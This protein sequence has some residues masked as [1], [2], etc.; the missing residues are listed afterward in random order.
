MGEKDHSDKALAGDGALTF[1]P[2]A[3]IDEVRAA[4]TD[5]IARAAL[6]ADICRLNTLYMIMQ[7]G[8]GHIGSSFSSTDLITWL[9]TEELVAANSGA[10]NADTYFSSKGH[11]A[12][13]LYSLLIALGKLDFDLLH[14]LRRLGGLPGH[15][16]V[17]TTPFVATNTGSLGM[18]IAKAYGMARARRFTGR[19]GRIVLMTGDGE[20][21]EGQVWESLQP[22][23]NERLS[24]IVA[25][26][27][28][29]KLQSDSAVS[30]VSDL[31]PLED[32]FR[33]F[34]WEVRRIDGHDFAAMRGAFAHFATVHDRPKV[35]IADT[36]KGKGVS[37]MEG[38]ACGD[39]T[40]HFHAGAPSLKDYLAA[41]AELTARLNDRLARIGWPPLAVAYAP[42]PARVAPAKPE[43]LVLAY[44]DE[45]LQMARART[46]IVVLDAD[47]L[48]DC[49]IEAFK[50]ELPDRFI[51]CG[52]AEQHMV[53]AAGGMALNGI[54][55]VVHSFACFLST[56]ANEQIYNNATERTKI[57]YTATLAGVVPGGP[58]HSHQSV[59][60]IS[61]VGSVPGLTAIEPCTEREARLAIRWAVEQNDASTYLRF[62]NVP[63]D[64]PYSLP[65][66]YAL[67]PG[68]GVTLRDGRDIALVG[69]GPLL[70]SNAWRAADELAAHGVGAAVINLPW[71][72]RIDD[73]WVADTFTAFKAIVTLD[74]H[75]VTLGQGV[76]IAAALAR[77]GIRASVCSIGLTDVPA[78]GSNAEVLAHHGLD[79]AGIARV[80]LASARPF[81][82]DV[83]PDDGPQLDRRRR[84]PR[85]RVKPSTSDR[86]STTASSPASRAARPPMSRHAVDAA[87]GA[88]DAWAPVAGAAPGRSA[89]P[90]RGAS[91][92]EGARLRR[93][94]PG[95]NREAVEE[96]GRRGRFV[97]RPGCVHGERRQ[98]LLRQDDD[99]S[100]SES[101]GADRA[102]AHRRVRGD[103]A[104]QQPAGGRGLESVSG[105]RSAA[106][107]SSRSRTS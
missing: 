56:R 55:P 64:L 106:T 63:L 29:N 49:G 52:I 41:V 107:P 23:A 102:S 77:T 65:P 68:R 48:S 32:K 37:F 5:P 2:K 46:D 59:R 95:G 96:R 99:E 24:E 47:L 98:P 42:L 75:Y 10:P 82:A 53:S 43:K 12:P 51:E 54:L 61:A 66:S 25:I 36:V 89:W 11:D 78:C 27:D 79:A 19:G 100:G 86:R 6:V 38:L 18:G 40:Y 73:G 33:A 1:V 105:A 91:A 93:D 69:Y 45:L 103:H 94:H 67:R 44:G 50:E 74:N 4:T 3:T 81:S 80:G 90:R 20:L 62:V 17:E 84:T 104:V 58:G 39:Q 88:A 31:G 87:A 71:L 83:Y 101:I 21:Q 60:D 30:A 22:T 92:R 34:G 70:M 57:V 13:A 97:R 14:K 72:N 76:M 16:D 85:R 8:S 7:A 9:W 35:I 28:H 26:V 15:P